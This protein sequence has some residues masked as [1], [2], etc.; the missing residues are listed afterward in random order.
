MID[1][2]Q[3]PDPPAYNLETIYASI[4]GIAFVFACAWYLMFLRPDI[5]P[6]IW[7]GLKADA[8]HMRD[9]TIA[10]WARTRR[11][12]R[13]EKNMEESEEVTIVEDDLR[14]AECGRPLMN[15]VII[16]KGFYCANC[17]MTPAVIAKAQEQFKKGRV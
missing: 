2:G 4:I 1:I 16:A 10:D 15:G 17:A 3:A 11:I 8:S 5:L 9:A 6:T 13:G 12:L 14:C 7:K